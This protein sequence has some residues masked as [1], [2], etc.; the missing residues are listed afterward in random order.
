MKRILLINTLIFI[1]TPAL[2]SDNPLTSAFL[3]KEENKNVFIQASLAGADGKKVCYGPLSPKR[4]EQAIA[5]I[6]DKPTN[7]FKDAQACIA[8]NGKL[9]EY[10]ER[11]SLITLVLQA[12]KQDKEKEEK[13]KA[14]QKFFGINF[15]LGLAFTKMNDPILREVSITRLSDAEDAMFQVRIDHESKNRAVAM[16]ESH[17][18]FE[19]SL[20]DE[21]PSLE[22]GHGPFI[23]IGIAG[24]Q[25]I[26]PLSTYGGG[27]MWGIKRSDGSSFNIGLGVYIDTQSKSLRDEFNDG[28]KT[29]IS[30]VSLL[31]R[32]SD[33]SGWMLM[34][35]SN[36]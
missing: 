14:N 19:K 3:L 2:A 23:A 6:A 10:E 18:F 31:T 33:K 30:D 34:F 17:Y 21:K 20:I 1:A 32:K 4:K 7:V 9:T 13:E 35:S 16:L 22:W 8:A 27:W 24:E 28:E 25:G 15:G 5:L 12:S 29:T 36:F 11:V 26:D